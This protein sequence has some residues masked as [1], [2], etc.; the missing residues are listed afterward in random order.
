MNDNL[1]EIKPISLLLYILIALAGFIL[2]LYPFLLPSIIQGNSSD[3]SGVIKTPILIVFLLSLCLLA[4]LYEVQGQ[5]MSTK[6]VALLGV[7]VAINA[8]LRFVENAIPGPG[9]F[10]PVFFLIIMTGYTYGGRFGFLMGALTLIVSAIITG[11]VGPWLPGQMFTAG[12]VGMT[13]PLCRP[14]VHFVHLWSV[15]T[16]LIKEKIQPIRSNTYMEIVILTGFGVLWGFLYG[17]IMNLWTWPF[18]I[19]PAEQFWTPGITLKDTLGRYV[20]YYLATSLVWDAA[21]A[22]GN[23]LLI[24][25]FGI[26]VLRVLRRFRSRFTFEY[27]PATS[28]TSTYFKGG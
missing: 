2:L 6:V 19:G 9:G 8:T 13:A 26:P 21:R 18:I 4:M 12:W 1:L 3:L 24:Y 7:L 16:P 23:G 14:L 10:S 20:T 27:H 28:K 17:A 5:V 11:G 25:L 22:I 15:K